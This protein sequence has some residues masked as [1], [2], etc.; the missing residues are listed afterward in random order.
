M[1][2]ILVALGLDVLPPEEVLPGE[3]LLGEVLVGEDVVL[4]RKEWISKWFFWSV[5]NANLPGFVPYTQWYRNR[6][7]HN[8]N[9]ERSKQGPKLPPPLQH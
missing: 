2:A 6:N 7:H 3:A 1:D 5:R 9:Q 4:G 8:Y